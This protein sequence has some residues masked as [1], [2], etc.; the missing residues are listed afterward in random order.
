MD[1]IT[2]AHYETEYLRAFLRMTGN[3]FQNFFSSVM[4]KRYPADFQRSR[5]WSTSGDRKNDGYLKSLRMLFGIYAPRDMKA[6]AT[7][8]KIDEDFR[9]AVPF[10]KQHF[11]TWVFVHND[12]DGLGPEIQTTL[13]ALGNEF[14]AL[15][16]NHWGFQELHDEIFRLE[17]Q[18]LV[19]L[20]GHGLRQRDLL[21][22][23]VDG[24]L[25]VLE[26][27]CMESSPVEPDLRPVP[28]HKARANKL[29]PSVEILL[30]AGRMRRRVVEKAF[31]ALSPFKPGIG[32]SL[33]RAFK[34]K[35]DELRAAGHAPVVS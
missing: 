12:Y 13:Y 33:A 3:E 10:W 5:P 31:H 30:Q 7:C 16:L 15:T 28:M 11:S 22:V 32:D 25:P 21:N 35:Y 1:P 8:K 9:G 18:H 2:R 27:L 23:S 26:L 4:E 6:T 19:S 14:P 29:S 24:L 34:A 20:F 17:Y